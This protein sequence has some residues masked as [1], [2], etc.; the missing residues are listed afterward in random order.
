MQ[1]IFLLGALFYTTPEVGNETNAIIEKIVYAIE[2]DNCP[3]SMKVKEVSHLAIWNMIQ[4][5]IPYSVQIAQLL[6][7][8][9][10]NNKRPHGSILAQHH[11]YFGIKYWRPYYPYRIS[12]QVYDVC[13][14]GYILAKDDCEEYCSF[15][16]FRS[17]Y[18][19]FKY[20]AYY[21]TVGDT[22]YKRSLQGYGYKSW[23]NSLQQNGY[24]SDPFYCKK[25]EDIII[26]YY[27]YEIDDYFNSKA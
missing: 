24:A 21:L 25:L 19:A 5:D 26:K 27:L 11:N 10:I 15:L 20:Y 23:L 18:L 17:P 14:T 8:S 2:Q 4:Y 7:E 16:T 6:L 12:E 22:R 3:G 1:M 13:V 9:G